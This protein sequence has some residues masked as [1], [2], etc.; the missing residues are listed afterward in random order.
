[1]STT[2][3]EAGGQDVAAAILGPL[4]PGRVCGGCTACC[5]LLDID[6]PDL[7]KPRDVLCVHCTGGGC[8]RYPDWPGICGKW[9]CAWRRIPSMPEFLRPDRLGVMFYLSVKPQEENLFAR[10]CMMGVPLNG[11][12]DLE[13]PNVRAALGVFSRQVGL[14][15]AVNLGGLTTLV[16]PHPDLARAI[17]DPALAANDSALAAEAGRWRKAMRLDP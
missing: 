2:G 14:P 13:Q 12:E 10:R 15:V 17:L 3:A 11:P 9:F 7:R 16:H 1:M 8:S 6:E 4:V 5:R